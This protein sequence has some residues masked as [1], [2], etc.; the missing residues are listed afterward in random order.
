MSVLNSLAFITQHPLTRNTRFAALARW[1][2]WQVG[3]RLLPGPVVV[4]FVGDARLIVRPGMTGATGNIYCGLHEFEDM[5]FVLHVLRPDDMFVDIG[6]NVG[7][8]TILGGSVGARGLSIEPIPATFSWLQQNIAINDFSHRV[9]AL[10]IGLGRSES[11][12]CFT[13][14]LD[15]VNHVLSNGESA[16]ETIDVPVRTLDAVLGDS[17][18]TLIKIDVEGFETEVMAGATESLAS[19]ELL[20]VIME[21]NGSGARYGFDESALHQ[22]MLDKGF[23]TFI[24]HPFERTLEPLQGTY[25]SGGNTLYVRDIEKI[26]ERVKTAPPVQVLNQAL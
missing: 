2:R 5:A 3:S 18:P 20:A 23:K 10:N 6:A 7:S 22:Q 8:Y 17:K 9:K 26:A 19:P 13:R 11:M 15:T 1:F 14:G 16:V 24:Y 21:L 25:A 4:P 12:L